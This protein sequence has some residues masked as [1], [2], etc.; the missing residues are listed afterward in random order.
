MKIFKRFFLVIG[1]LLVLAIGALAAA[2]FLFKDKILALVKTKAN[3]ELNATLSFD[4][5]SLSFFKSFPDLTVTLNDV[6][7]KNHAPFDSIYLF[8]GEKVSA[9]INLKSLMGDNQAYQVKKIL[10]DITL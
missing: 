7:V 10:L 6:N 9:T 3:E 8:K 2:P 4:D 5:V 1:V